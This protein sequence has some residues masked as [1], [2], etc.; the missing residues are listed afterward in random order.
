MM[1]R[2]LATAAATAILTLT[3]A[4]WVAVAQ[5]DPISDQCAKA[6]IPT[7]ICD[8]HGGVIPGGQVTGDNDSPGVG[9]VKQVGPTKYFNGLGPDVVY[10]YDKD[11]PL[12]NPDGTNKVDAQ[13]NQMYA[14]I[15]GPGDPTYG[16]KAGTEAGKTDADGNRVVN[17]DGYQFAK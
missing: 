1:N 3:G 9:N 13:G 12:K 8:G 17:E 4:G 5:A 7:A 10:G 16:T 14:P 2:I 6:T 11:Q 15:M